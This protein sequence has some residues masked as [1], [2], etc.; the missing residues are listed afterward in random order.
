MTKPIVSVVG[1]LGNYQSPSPILDKLIWSGSVVPPAFVAAEQLS[2]ASMPISA[3]GN[4]PYVNSFL[5]LAAAAPQFRV[6]LSNYTYTL[7][8]PGTSQ[9]WFYDPTGAGWL[10]KSGPTSFNPPFN[11]YALANIDFGGNHYLVVADYDSASNNGG[12]LCLL[13]MSSADVYATVTALSIPNKTVTVDETTYTYQAHVQDIYVDDNRIFV[14]V[15]YSNIDSTVPPS[16]TYINSEVREYELALQGVNIVFSQ[17]GDP[18]EIGKNAVSLVPYADGNDK[19]LFIPAIGGMQSN[20]SNNGADSG[21]YVI[22]VTSDMEEAQQAY[23]GG[24]YPTLHD[25]HG[26][27]ISTNGTA[28]ILTGDYDVNYNMDWFLYQTTAANLVALAD[29]GSPGTIPPA[30]Q[31]AGTK[32]Y[33]AYFW[34][35]G[36]CSNG[37]NEFL[38]FGK[39]GNTSSAASANAHD[40]VHF[41]QVG[42]TWSNTAN[43]VNSIIPDTALNAGAP[44]GSGFAINSM[45]VSVPGGTVRL[46]T[47]HHHL[48]PAQ[49]K[50]LRA[51]AVE[52]A[53]KK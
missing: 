5:N 39:G 8:N 23:I 53:E 47:A 25:F 21:L 36:I 24:T 22:D 26:I 4:A 17:V 2:G 44:A 18:V 33:T 14:L 50:A 41:L 16:L 51:K 3:Y 7:G 12:T 45:D 13:S 6:A 40:E 52:E 35:L 9:F 32:H 37:T 38:V 20:G 1:N 30:L 28:Y 15:I 43:A 42:A 48:H 29:A 31:I 19:Y 11:P 34:S 27:A 10:L 49:V 46:K